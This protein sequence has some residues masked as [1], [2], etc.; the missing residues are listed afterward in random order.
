MVQEK[1]GPLSPEDLDTASKQASEKIES[2]VTKAKSGTEKAGSAKKAASSSPD[3]TSTLVFLAEA[4]LGQI[5]GQVIAA[6][7]GNEYTEEDDPIRTT[8]ASLT[9][10]SFGR[11]FAS[12]PKLNMEAAIQ[13]ASAFTTHQMEV[14]VDYFT[15]VDDLRADLEGDAG[16]GHIDTAEYTSGVFYSFIAIDIAQ[17]KHNWEDHE[18]YNA[19]DRLALLI[20]ELL[21]ALPSGK[22]SSTAPLTVPNYVLVEK[23]SHAIQYAPAFDVPVRP[24]ANGGGLII[25]SIEALKSECDR[26]RQFSGDML[27]VHDS[28]TVERGGAHNLV[29]VCSWAAQQILA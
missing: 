15:A 13:V 9:V 10:A 3:A 28:M 19:E 29:D 4:E 25:P 11:M 18:S 12:A 8:T 16:A 6:L 21:M 5:A 1:L 24:G 27:H 26:V 23:A 14:D 22:R 2:L 7:S 20:R 17:L